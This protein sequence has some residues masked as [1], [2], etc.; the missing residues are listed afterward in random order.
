MVNNVSSF[1]YNT[2]LGKIIKWTTNLK[3]IFDMNFSSTAIYNIAR[4]TLQAN[5]NANFYTETLSAEI[6]WYSKSDCIG[7][8]DFDYMYNGNRAAGYNTSVPLCSPSV[9]KQV[10]K[11][12][13]GE[14]RLSIFNLLNQ[15]PM[16]PATLPPI[17]FR[18]YVTMY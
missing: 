12:K 10:F 1:T 14:F 3:K 16:L 8:S 18:I 4:Y 2:T 9:A 6:T 17:P 5:Q 13:A 15:K 11:N 7:A